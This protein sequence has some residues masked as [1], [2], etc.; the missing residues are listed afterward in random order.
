[1]SRIFNFFF[2]VFLFTTL[3]CSSDSIAS[4]SFDNV[5]REVNNTIKYVMIREKVRV[6]KSRREGSNYSCYVSWDFNKARLLKVFKKYFDVY[7]INN[8]LMM[9]VNEE[10]PFSY[11]LMNYMNESQIRIEFYLGESYTSEI[12]GKEV[13]AVGY[14]LSYKGTKTINIYSVPAHIKRRYPVIHVV[15]KK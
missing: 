8:T 6:A 1:M 11:K 12:V 15:K 14:L 13:F 9:K 3:L 5:K 10:K 7:T 2:I 4:T